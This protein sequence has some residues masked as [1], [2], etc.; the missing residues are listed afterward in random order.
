MKHFFKT[1]L[2]LFLAVATF[3]SCGSKETEDIIEEVEEGFVATI[4]DEINFFIWRGL[5]TFYL[6]QEDVPDLSDDKFR[7]DE[8]TINLTDLYRFF[9]KYN[10]PEQ[11][12]DGLLYRKG[13]ID[14]FSWIVDDFVALENSFQGISTSNGM[15]FGLVQNRDGSNNVFGYVRYVVANSSAAENGVSRGMYFNTVNGTNITTTNF[16]D[17][18]FGSATSYTIGLADYNRGNPT[19]NGNSIN[20]TKTELQENPVAV[21]ETLNEGGKKIGYLMYNQFSASFDS[22][23][24]AAFAKFKADNV[25]ELI[26]DLRYNGGGSVRSAVYLGSMIT[27]Q[28]NGQVYSRQRW[29]SKVTA[30]FSAESFIDNFT[31]RIRNTD[32]DGNVIV[33]ESINSLNLEKVYFI[34]SDNTASASELV[35]NALNAYID[36]SIVGTTTVGKQVGSITLYDS[37]DLQRNGNRL[38]TKH[39]YAMQPLVLE[40]V[41]KNNENDIDGYTPVVDI[42][43]VEITEDFGN[44]GQLGSTSDPLLNATVNL[45]TNSAKGNIETKNNIRLK[46][47][48]NSA[49]AKPMKDNMYIDL[50]DL[51]LK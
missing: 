19:S 48:Y 11:T 17:L 14:R 35:I 26:V 16:R 1:T 20:L 10:S 39:A 25:N 33:D 37:E 36:V 30:E 23:M 50:G 45:I 29:N 24:N 31:D 18:L 51:Q 49:I 5:N 42:P 47:L 22:Q 21:A 38:N 12:F 43:G 41:N 27:G 8:N 7:V 34:V 9:R 13:D 3:Y 28:F 6:W 15:E 46:E 40:I 44:L 32:G 2:L 4:D